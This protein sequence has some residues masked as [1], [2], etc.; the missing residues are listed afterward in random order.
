MNFSLPP[1]PPPLPLHSS[2]LYSP[3]SLLPPLRSLTRAPA[4]TIVTPGSSSRVHLAPMERASCQC[5]FFLGSSLCDRYGVGRVRIRVALPGLCEGQESTL[6]ASRRPGPSHGHQKERERSGQHSV[7]CRRSQAPRV[8][9]LCE[10]TASSMQGYH[11]RYSRLPRQ[12]VGVRTRHL[13][14]VWVDGDDP[15]EAYHLPLQ[16]AFPAA[17]AARQ[18]NRL[19]VRAVAAPAPS[20][21]SRV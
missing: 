13:P 1:L 7:F 19:S 9:T 20:H 17:P 10:G 14:R 12:H 18:S 15:G 21:G 5:W 3:P 11:P 2:I 8:F 6:G 16:H 4:T